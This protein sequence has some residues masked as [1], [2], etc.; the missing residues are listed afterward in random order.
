MNITKKKQTTVI[1]SKLVVTR[2]RGQ[3][4]GQ[5]SGRGLRGTTYNVQNKL[6]GYIIQHREYSQYFI[7]NYKCSTTFKN[8]E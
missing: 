6:Q 5:D 2:G 3:R 4:E 8:C 7:N 1:Q